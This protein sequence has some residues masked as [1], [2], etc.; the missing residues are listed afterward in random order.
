[1]FDTPDHLGEYLKQQRANSA[2]LIGES[3]FQA[4]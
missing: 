3:G 2:K 4:R 1:V